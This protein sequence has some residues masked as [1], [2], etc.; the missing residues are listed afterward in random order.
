LEATSPLVHK[1]RLASLAAT[2]GRA[3][4]L[5]DDYQNL[6]SAEYTQTK[7]FCEDLDEGKYSLPIIHMLHTL[8]SYQ[9]GVLHN[10]LT[11]RRLKGSM[12]IEQKRM[13]LEMMDQAGSLDY[14][15]NAVRRLQGDMEHELDVVEQETGVENFE[16]RALFEMIKI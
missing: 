12:G 10:L 4:A 8:P 7:G 11:Q 1:P 3:Y 13:V 2:L 6:A 16:L 5:R 9:R 14:T 15:L